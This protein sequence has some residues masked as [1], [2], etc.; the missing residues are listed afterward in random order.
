MY[1]HFGKIVFGV[2]IVIAILFWIFISFKASLL[3]IGTYSL[4]MF[5]L[6]SITALCNA[7]VGREL[8]VEGDVFWK[9][10]FILCFCICYSIYFTI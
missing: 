9:T 3:F 5:I 1:K 4:M 8:P 6:T 10:L 2:V 7:L